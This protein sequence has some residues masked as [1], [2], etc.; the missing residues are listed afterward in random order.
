[1]TRAGRRLRRGFHTLTLRLTDQNGRTPEE[2]GPSTPTSPDYWAL[3]RKEFPGEF[4]R[5]ATLSREL[6]ARLARVNGVRVSVD[7]VPHDH[8]T[9]DAIAPECD[10][11]CQL[12]EEEME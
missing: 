3:I 8:P 5:M 11:L 1:M 2:I 4:A 7:E 12:S 6:G 9:T 10:L